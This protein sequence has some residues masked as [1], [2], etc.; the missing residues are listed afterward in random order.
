MDILLINDA[1][2]RQLSGEWNVVKAA[3]AIRALG[4]RTLVIKKGEHGV[5][6]FSEEGSFAAPAYPLEEVFDPTG[7][8]DTFAGGFLGYLAGVGDGRRGGPAPRGHHGEHARVVLRR[9]LQPRPAA[10]PVPARDRRALP[11]LQAAHPLRGGLASP[12]AARA[13][14]YTDLARMPGRTPRP[15]IARARRSPS[16]RACSPSGSAT[17]WRRLGIAFWDSETTLQWAY[18]ADEYFHAA[19]TMKLAVLLGVYRQV[20]RGE[21]TLDAPVHVRNKFRSVVDDQLYMLD[22]DRDA[23][24]DLYR[25]LG[26]TM[27]VQQLA[28]AMITTS[29]NFATNLLVDVVGVSTIQTALAELGI[30]GVKVVRGVEDQAAFDAGINNEVTA[31]GLLKLLR[32]LAEGKAYG[33]EASAEMLKILHEQ[34]FKGG[35]PAGLPQAARVAHKTGNIATVHHDAGI[36]YLENRKPYALVILTQFHSRE[37]ARHGGGGRLARHLR[38]PGRHEPLKFSARARGAPM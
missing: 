24:P 10:D 27:T 34:R 19:S 7:A 18:N 28:Y 6:M 23:D 25:N 2:A 36:V 31:A 33:E 17:A 26:R 12:K 35:I 3:R 13:L 14:S 5:L 32:V 1:E 21:L 20:S 29:S 9:G 30:D 16:T 37:P 4:P 11:A 8:G 22:F 38:V 15:S